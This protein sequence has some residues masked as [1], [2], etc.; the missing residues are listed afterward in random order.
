M[1]ILV[2]INSSVNY[3]SFMI[4]SKQLLSTQLSLCI[5]MQL[6]LSNIQLVASKNT[7][8]NWQVTTETKWYILF[9]K[10]KHELMPTP[11]YLNFEGQLS[12]KNRNVKLYH[13]NKYYYK[14]LCPPSP[15]LGLSELH[16]TIKMCTNNKR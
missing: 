7:E 12:R 3:I 4:F 13:H 1:Y 6:G 14:E 2:T 5:R 11:F 10:I 15:F 16:L 9:V 8:N